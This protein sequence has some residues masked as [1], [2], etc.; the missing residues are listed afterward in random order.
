LAYADA[1]FGRF[2]DFL[3]TN[4]TLENT[5]VVI[6]SDHGEMFERGIRGHVTPT[7]Y[8]PVIRVPLLISTPNQENRV[9]IKD[10]TNHVDILPTLLNLTGKMSADWIEGN[11]LPPFKTGEDTSPRESYCVEA[12]SNA[13]FAPLRKATISLVKGHHKLI[14]YIGQDNGLPSFEFFD[15]K[16][17]PEELQDLGKS[18]VAEFEELQYKIQS[19]LIS[20]NQGYR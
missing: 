15:L 5:I 4:G 1:E 16:N 9:D 11:V 20:V 8:Q 13:K 3:L 6:T 14:H 19:K 18:L 2:Y 17:D 7:L 12:K 10:V